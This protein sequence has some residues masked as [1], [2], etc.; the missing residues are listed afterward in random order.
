MSSPAPAPSVG[1][2]RSPRVLLRE[3]VGALFRTETYA[4]L[5]YLL[6]AFPLGVAYFTLVVVGVTFGITTSLLLIGVPVLVITFVGVAALGAVEARLAAALLGIETSPPEAL[7]GDN[8]NGVRRAENGLRE[9]LLDL[10]T[11][12]TTWTALV[13]VLLKFVYGT[14]VFTALVT[15]VAVTA[16]FVSAPVVYDHPDVSYAV[17]AY[18]IETLPEALGLA[19]VGVLVGLGSVQLLTR[20]ATAGGL[21]TAALLNVNTDRS[22]DPT[23]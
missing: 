13:L 1:S 5:L 23:A 10:F 8:P 12:P 6:L 14:V 18:A 7:R 17:G 4:K 9:A 16:S 11:A 19:A 15:V 21:V 22:V 3:F 2:N 20:L